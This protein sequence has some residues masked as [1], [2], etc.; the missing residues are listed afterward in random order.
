MWN[1]HNAMLWNA[2]ATDGRH[3]VDTDSEQPKQL[4]SCREVQI[5]VNP[6]T[7]SETLESNHDCTKVVTTRWQNSNSTGSVNSL[8]VTSGSFALSEGAKQEI[9][10]WEH[11]DLPGSWAWLAKRTIWTGDGL[12]SVQHDSESFLHPLGLAWLPPC[13]ALWPSVKM[14]FQLYFW[15]GRHVCL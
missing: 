3:G 14:N 5:Q 10:H 12:I 8:R 11:G 2:L 9:Q 15:R 4:R 1:K 7:A 6:D 13:Y